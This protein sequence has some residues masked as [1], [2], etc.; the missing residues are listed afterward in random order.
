M[1]DQTSIAILNTITEFIEQHGFPP[2]VREIME[3]VNS[4]S[5]SVVRRHL[6]KLSEDGFIERTP[7]VARGIVVKRRRSQ[8][9]GTYPNVQ[10]ER[11]S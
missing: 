10:G 11:Q 6:N 5:T 3:R 2:S 1:V 4:K 7:E 9:D 8:P